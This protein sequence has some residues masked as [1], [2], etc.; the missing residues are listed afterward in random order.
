MTQSAPFLNT[1]TPSKADVARIAAILHEA[2]GI[3][4]APGKQ[5]MVQSRL[6]K[7]L[8]ALGLTDFASYLAL[9]TS[10]RGAEERRRMVSALTTNVTHFFREAHH[11]ETLRTKVLPPLLQHAR[12]RQRVRLWSA[13]CSSGQEA[14]SIAMTIADL[15]GPDLDRLDLK[16][17]A[18]DI[19]GD[20][21]ARG[22]AALYDAAS[23]EGVP[24]AMRQRFL[25]PEAGGFRVVPALRAMVSFRELNLHDRWPMKG[26]FD[27]IFCRNVVIYFD[28]PTQEKLWARFETALTPGGWLFVGHS[29]RVPLRANGA[30]RTAGITTYRRDEIPQNGDPTW[31]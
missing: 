12:A 19:D 16:I 22:T 31:H 24:D 21:V 3:V 20:M 6:A 25:T 13:G 27:V 30:L 18:T 23:I 2:A 26:C 7:R 1:P 4:I 9:V 8:R 17:L 29:E 14:Y 11:F 5:S 28:A 15:A 10:D